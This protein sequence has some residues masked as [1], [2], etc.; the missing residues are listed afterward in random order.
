[1]PLLNVAV[2]SNLDPSGSPRLWATSHCVPGRYSKKVSKI[3]KICMTFLLF[4]SVPIYSF[5]P[6]PPITTSWK[7]TSIPHK[8]LQASHSLQSP[9][10]AALR[11]A[12]RLKFANLTYMKHLYNSYV[13]TPCHVISPTATLPKEPK[14]R[15]EFTKMVLT[16]S[17]ICT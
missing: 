14:V 2:D 3:R 9:Y 17:L 16:P 1:M 5:R 4:T 11:L 7:H 6:M 13:E 10:M 15:F 12:Y 8:F